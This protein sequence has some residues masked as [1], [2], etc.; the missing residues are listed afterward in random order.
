MSLMSNEG[1]QKSPI[2]TKEASMQ[3]AQPV[4]HLLQ[5]SAGGARGGFP[6]SP[7]GGMGAPPPPYLFLNTRLS[8]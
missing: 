8:Y 1:V 7:P 6:S 4:L 5:A 3:L 2:N